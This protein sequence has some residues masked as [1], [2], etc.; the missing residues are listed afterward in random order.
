MLTRKDGKELQAVLLTMQKVKGQSD[1][2]FD[3]IHSELTFLIF[4][5]SWKSGTVCIPVPSTS[6]T[7][8]SAM[9]HKPVTPDTISAAPRKNVGRTA[10][11][12]TFNCCPDYVKHIAIKSTLVFITTTILVCLQ[13]MV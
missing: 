2:D 3:T 12:A 5:E 4:F 10:A 6:Q 7:S 1:S 9:D 8:A 13:S 11:Q